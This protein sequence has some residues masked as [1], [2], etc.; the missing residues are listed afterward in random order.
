MPPSLLFYV[1][2]F[3]FPLD[4][5]YISFDCCKRHKW[6]ILFLHQ[7]TRVWN[8]VSN[9]DPFIN[10][11]SSKVYHNHQYNLHNVHQLLYVSSSVRV[12][13]RRKQPIDNVIRIFSQDLWNSSSIRWM[14]PIWYLHPKF[15]QPS[16]RLSLRCNWIIHVGLWHLFDVSVPEIPRAFYLGGATRIWLSFLIGNS[17]LRFLPNSA[18][19]LKTG[20]SSITIAIIAVWHWNGIDTSKTRRWKYDCWWW[21]GWSR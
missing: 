14:E 6:S 4:R 11:V 15:Q 21:I 18:C 10:K 2:F 5:Y 12:D 3:L 19:Q 16:C 8:F 17:R 9:K 1:C 20:T 7:F 13:V